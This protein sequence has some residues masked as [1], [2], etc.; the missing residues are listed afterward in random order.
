MERMI[1]VAGGRLFVEDEG[2][3]PPIVLVHAS[4]ANLSA[5]DGVVPG[6][7]AAGF[8]VVRYD[9]RGWG[10]SPAEAVLYSNR[11]DLVAVLDGCGIGRAAIAGNSRGGTIVLDT[12]LEHPDRV[13]ATVMIAS[14][15][16]GWE[17]PATPDEM[18][19]FD[20]ME[21][22]NAAEPQDVDAI[23]ALD[24]AAWVDGPGQS[25]GRAPAAVRDAIA[26]WDR[27][28]YEP[29]H[30]LGKAIPL[31]PPAH[32]RLDGPAG[33][34]LVISGAFDFSDTRAAGEML[35]E[36]VGARHVVVPDVAHMVAM[37]APSEVVGLVTA[38]L[39]P[40]RPWS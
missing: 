25:A 26:T 38:F 21:R 22:L 12:A 20:E 4:I 33:P 3:G 27:V 24:L 39:E 31:D 32:A 34:L 16:G 7:V 14:T 6:L 28:V 17:G 29:G 30:I 8:R 23:V 37:E 11:A 18:A 36:R 5:W 1:D 19:L 9:T 2:E 35:A 15:P 13:V 40:L 10:R